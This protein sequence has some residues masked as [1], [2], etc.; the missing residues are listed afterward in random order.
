ATDGE[1]QAALRGERE[2]EPEFR[3]IRPDGTVRNI[4]AASKTYYDPQ[5]K[6][7]RMVGTNIDITE[8]KRAEATRT[9]LAAIVESSDDAIIGKTTDGIIT[10]WN[11]GAERMYGYTADE[12][13][14]Q[15]VTIFAPPSR[16]AEIREF[17]ERINNGETVANHESERLRKDGTPIYVSL[18]LSPIRDASGHVTGISTITRDVTEKRRMEE[19]L[20]EASVYNRSLIEA[21]MDPLVTISLEGKITDVN[22]ATEAVTGRSRSELIGTDFLDYFSEPDKARDGYRQVFA[23]GYV[24]DYPLALRH[25]D[26]HLTEVLYNASVYRDESGKVLGVFAAA[27][28]VTKRNK[29]EREVRQLSQQNR[30]ILDSAGEGIYG[31]DINGR[32]TFVNPAAAQ[33]LGFPV[34]E[35]LGQSSHPLFH[36]TKPDGSPYPQEECPVHAAYKRGEVQHGS[37]LYWHKDG[38]SFSVEFISTPILESGEITGAVVTFRDITERKQAEERLR[39]SEE[40]LKEAQRIAHLGSWHMYLATNEVFWSE[41]LYKMYGFDPALPPPLYTESMKLFT[42]ESWEKLSA[43][44][45][46]AAEANIPYEIELEMVPKAGGRGWMLARGEPI[47]GESGAVVEIRGVV[48]DITERKRAE[49]KLRRSEHGLAEAQ[50]IAHLG[51]W[52]LDLVSSVLTWSD[53]IYRIFEIDPQ[54]FGASYEAFLNAIHPDDRDMVNKAYTDSV[55]DKIPYDIVHRLQMPDGR[56]KYVNEKCETYYD[57]DGKPLRSVGTVHDITEQKLDEEALQRLNRELRAISNCNETLMRAEDEQA[58]LDDICRIVCDDAGYLMAW[59]GYP[60][61][62]EARTIRLISRAGADSGYLEQAQ[63]TWADTA[64]GRGPSGTAIRSGKSVSIQDFSAD[65]EAA[66]WR[67]AAL[68]RGYRSSIALPLKDENGKVFG[69]LNIYAAMPDAF[70]PEEVRLLE[71][72][73][74]DMAFGIMVLHTRIERREAEEEVRALNR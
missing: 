29:A 14:G 32:C 64:R 49:E 17:L 16:H 52:E 24:T 70:T 27:R 61:N 43:S 56:I 34:E 45:T 11:K 74:G 21:S 28:D 2:Y 8:H 72:L 3:I 41:E 55:A 63:L 10:S 58:L 37:D 1:I 26:G 57:K 39:R 68:Q 4:K 65:P 33:M 31:L 23:Q 30:L 40:G 67:E 46:R 7:L 53:E 48:M 62:D 22:K 6:P 54:R 18:T 73:A 20:R 59:V 13:I 47:L 71:E 42:P 12:V 15:S 5:G 25:R 44:I 66:P 50:R 38:S 35:L 36:H 9:Q 19:E 60:Q 69:I 51:N